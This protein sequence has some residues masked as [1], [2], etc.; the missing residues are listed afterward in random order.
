MD[1]IDELTVK[2]VRKPHKSAD[3][4]SNN[5]IKKCEDKLKLEPLDSSDIDSKELKPNIKKI[6]EEIDKYPE[7]IMTPHSS[8]ESPPKSDDSEHGSNCDLT[9]T[10]GNSP[11]SSTNGTSG[12]KTSNLNFQIGTRLEAKD[13]GNEIWYVFVLYLF[14]VQ[15]F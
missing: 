1:F 6:K 5:G 11:D 2:D 10:N 13:L 14:Y 12:R 4:S 8:Y 9:S 15:W 3:T 7:D